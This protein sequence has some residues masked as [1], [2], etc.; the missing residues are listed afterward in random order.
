MIFHQLFQLASEGEVSGFCKIKGFLTVIFLV[1]FGSRKEHLQFA[2]SAFS[3]GDITVHCT[4][5]LMAG[6][7]IRTKSGICAGPRWTSLEE[8][9]A[10]LREWDFSRVTV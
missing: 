8:R 7:G 5:G 10:L 4:L 3:L 2:E 1:A 6:K 9:V